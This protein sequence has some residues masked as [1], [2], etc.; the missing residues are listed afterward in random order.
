MEVA[1][2]VP[3]GRIIY[4]VNFDLHF[5]LFLSHKTKLL[6]HYILRNCD[7]VDPHHRALTHFITSHLISYPSPHPYK[8]FNHH[9]T[10]LELIHNNW[11]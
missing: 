4:F 3:M 11:S 1:T 7:A 5:Q 9:T 6:N 2:H 10:I 8:P